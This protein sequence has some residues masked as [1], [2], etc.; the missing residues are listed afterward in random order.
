MKRRIL[1]GSGLAAVPLV[2]FWCAGGCV[3]RRAPETR[4]GTVYAAEGVTVAR[5]A[6]T[7]SPAG[8]KLALA[9]LADAKAWRF[10]NYLGRLRPEFGKTF[11]GRECLYIGGTEKKHDAAWN[12]VSPR[13]RLSVP[14]DRWRLTFVLSAPMRVFGELGEK[15]D[16][17]TCVR[18]F[19][20]DGRVV[21]TTPFV[22][23]AVPG[24]WTE[25]AVD[26]DVPDGAAAAE[27]QL[28]FDTP[29]IAPGEYTAFSDFAFQILDGRPRFVRKGV[30]ESNV[31][32]AGDVS[33]T[34]EVP[35]G[36]KV[37]FQYAAAG[38][39]VSALTAPFRGPDGTDA[40]FFERPFAVD[41]R[42]LRYRVSLLSADGAASPCL[43]TVCVGGRAEGRWTTRRD[44]R[45]PRVRIVS[46]TPTTNRFESVRLEIADDSILLPE[47]FRATVDGKDMTKSF[48]PCAGG[49]AMAR[50]AEGWTNGLHEVCVELSDCRGNVCR[51]RRYFFVG[52]PPPDVPRAELRDDGVTLVDG[53]PFFPVGVYA[54][55]RRDFNGNDLDRAFRGL[56]EG[57][58]NFAHTYFDA[59]DPEFLAAAGKYGIRLW[60]RARTPDERF[61]RHGIG[62]PA[63]LAWYLGD[64]TSNHTTAEQLMSYD[65]AVKAA[66]PN[67]LTCQADPI[68]SKW[69]YSRYA[70]YVTGT[71][72]FI[73][74]IY[75]LRRPDKGDGSDRRCVAEAIR[76]MRR[77]R[78]DVERY[79]DGRP[80]ACWPVIQYFK[81]WNLW[82]IMP[83]RAQLYGMTWGTVIHGANGVVWYTYGGKVDPAKGVD[84][85]GVTSSPETWETICGLARQLSSFAEV[86][87]AR[88]P[89]QPPLP[90]VT[91][92]PEK[93]PC[94]QPAVTCLLK[95]HGGKTCL[96]AVN[97]AADPVRARF[98]L[99][100]VS[101]EIAVADE[102][103]RVVKAADGFEDGFGPF[104]VHIYRWS[105]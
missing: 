94:G 71:D 21:A 95:R 29:N 31:L 64:D 13:M 68:Y 103:G 53:K 16:Y 20:D 43:R 62:N 33:W 35:R 73:P 77:V 100:G 93:D 14:G 86:L 79:G 28:G 1:R 49:Y 74:E 59:Y 84:N 101:G 60:V 80:R 96:F 37:L 42:Y 67:R 88:T 44:D 55:S 11:G 12:V 9:P 97:S 47:T 61:L 36:T 81:G 72:V 7:L 102:D 4:E 26:G 3:E 89:A 52:A 32:P 41:A 92:G 54:V 8:E 22:F 25:C 34:A 2:A 104:E 48:T 18:W 39:P 57:G 6:V 98:A 78:A 38:D 63:I 75:P 83:S 56:K 66:D 91:S 51:A 69:G 85:R 10:K 15:D 105:P 27:F 40:T 19:G 70:D 46:T 17:C 50:P 99:P 24:G 23:H 30:F 82:G 90:Q 65:S 87:T 5:D 58:F 45:P 76:D